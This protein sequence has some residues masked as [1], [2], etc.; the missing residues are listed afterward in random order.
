MVPKRSRRTA[1]LGVGSIVRRGPDGS[2]AGLSGGVLGKG[3]RK[4]FGLE[5]CQCKSPVIPLSQ[6][7]SETTQSESKQ[8]TSSNNANPFSFEDFDF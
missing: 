2:G 5:R 8:E 3:S 4:S 6:K 1:G 7:A